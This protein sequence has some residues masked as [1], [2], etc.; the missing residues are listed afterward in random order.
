MPVYQLGAE[1][2]FPPANE[3]EEHGVVAIGGDLSA[4]R[5]V[6]AYQQGIFPWFNE[7][8]PILWWC[9]E[10]RMVLK[11][12]EV[13]ISKSLRNVLNR[14]KFQI[15]I[16]TAFEE[17]IHQCQNINRQGQDGTWINEDLKSSFIELHHQGLAHSFEC[18]ENNEL[19]GG[20]YG[21]ALGNVFS[22]ESMFSK[23]SNA[24]KVAFTAMCSMLEKLDFAYVDCQMYNSFLASLGAY[25][26]DR[27]SFLEINDNSHFG[28]TIK[29][30]W[31]G[32]LKDS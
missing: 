5:I 16:D 9:P 30:N 23:V 24:S 17:V 2:W 20:L 4:D 15:K 10:K 7:G 27:P 25:E 31:S 21:L 22:G 32:F 19:V 26:I 3:F 11:P 18:W 12:R 28:D 8:E 29:G 1:L 14:K 13:K 6:L